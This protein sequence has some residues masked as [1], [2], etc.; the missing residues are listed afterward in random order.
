MRGLQDLIPGRRTNV[1]ITDGGKKVSMLLA[2]AR[3]QLKGHR[4]EGRK[5]SPPELFYNSKHTPPASNFIS[6]VRSH[7]WRNRLSSE[8]MDLHQE[9]ATKM[10]ASST[11][12]PAAAVMATMTERVQKRVLDVLLSTSTTSPMKKIAAKVHAQLAHKDAAFT[13]VVSQFQ[14]VQCSQEI[15]S[16][17]S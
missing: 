4:G 9:A 13:S 12:A 7:A 5:K 14:N 8:P 3:K 10:A 16:L 1:T 2:Q 6:N 11:P 17:G 15:S